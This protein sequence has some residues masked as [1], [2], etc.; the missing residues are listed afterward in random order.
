MPHASLQSNR[1]NHADSLFSLS[2]RVVAAGGSPAEPRRTPVVERH[3]VVVAS[4]I[5]SVAIFPSPPDFCFQP[6]QLS[7]MISNVL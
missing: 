2:L 5:D 6:Q 4:S 1:P 7:V 3:R